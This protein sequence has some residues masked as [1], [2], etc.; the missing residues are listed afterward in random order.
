MW[1][2]GPCSPSPGAAI[3]LCEDC[4]PAAGGRPRVQGPHK[5]Q[6]GRSQGQQTR[7]RGGRGCQARRWQTGCPS[8]GAPT[9]GSPGRSHLSLGSTPAGTASQH[10]L[11]QREGTQPQRGPPAHLLQETAAET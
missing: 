3:G 6:E 7:G 8:P 2:W 9:A 5:V 11:S 1:P 4:I 10:S